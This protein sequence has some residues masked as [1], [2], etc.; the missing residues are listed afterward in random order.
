MKQLIRRP[1]L[2]VILLAGVLAT[3]SAAAPKAGDAEPDF[4]ALHATVDA[5]AGTP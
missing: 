2:F 3:I 5:T 4:K 1:V